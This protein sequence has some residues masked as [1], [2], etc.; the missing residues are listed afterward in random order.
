MRADTRGVTRKT[1]VP[2]RP[3]LTV[4]EQR[5]L[6]QS[7]SREYSLQNIFKYGYRN[8]EDISNLPPSTL[9]LGSQ[10]MLTNAADLVGIRQGYVLD[11]AAGTQNDYGIDSSYDFSNRLG[12]TQN[13]RKWGT[14][15]ELRYVNPDTSTVSWINILAT[16]TATKVVNFTS[17][18]DQNT[19]LKTFCLFVNGNSNVYEWSGG[20]GS[21][22]SATA[23]TI[24]I[25]GTTTT[26]Q[27]GFYDNAANSAKFIVTINGVDYTYTGVTGETFTGVSPSPLA[28]GVQGDAVIQKPSATAG[29]GIATNGSGNLGSFEFDLIATLEN[30][31]W[32]GSFLQNSLYVSKTNNYKDVS[33]STPA[34]LPAEGALIVLDAIPVA[35]SPQASQMYIGAGRDQWWIS[36]KNQ[37]TIDVSGVAT[38]VET[39]YVARLKTALNQAPQSQGLVGRYKNSL[40]F[41]SNEPIINALGL[42]QNIQQDPQVTNMSDPIKY[43]VDAYNFAGG[44][45]L[46]DNYFIYVTVPI[47]GV[48]RMYNVQ[49]QYWEVPQTIPVSRLYHTNS[50][51]GG[52]IYGHSSLTNESY[53]LFTGYNDNGN[54]INAVAA[55][56]YVSQVGGSAPEKKNFNKIYTEGYIASN[57]TVMLTINYDFGGYSGTYTTVISGSDL[58][59]I[60]NKVTDGSLGQNSLGS[61]PIGTILNVPNAPAIP[62]FRVINTM[63]R[64]NCF[65]YQMVYSSNDVDQNFTL[66]RFGPAVTS[67]PEIPVEITQ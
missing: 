48:L 56:P 38:P 49:K 59:I 16:L 29:S 65:E 42:V 60:F 6:L 18:W 44:Q 45:V 22:L 46:Y 67:A 52:A 35:F 23:N 58:S 53:E 64:V 15:L 2:G 47:N 19:E 55:F 43:D 20:V 50:V 37:Q 27:L 17:F 5:G 10:N 31:V 39:L 30:Q 14:N 57:T 3:T 11:G 54:P 4:A 40:I 63:P 21:F 24:T 25:E 33:F 61:Q 32:Y 8:K 66:L 62:K 36:Q 51:I 34:R 41:V 13:L 1:P 12:A 28:A 26:S 9:V 7:R